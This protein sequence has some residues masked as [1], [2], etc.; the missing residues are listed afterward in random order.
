MESYLE[1]RRRIKNEGKQVVKKK[2]KKIRPFSDKRAK[3]NREYYNK[4]RP[5]WKG[6]P[7]AI[8]AK[9]C[10]GAA[11]GIHHLAGK[12]TIELLMDE[13]NWVPACN[14][15][16]LWCETHHAKAVKKGFKRSRLNKKK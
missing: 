3:V 1:Y 11:Q 16:N 9:D 15:C 7:C 10:T 4:S 5:Y 8:R 6:N 14:A 12:D 13:S 2:V